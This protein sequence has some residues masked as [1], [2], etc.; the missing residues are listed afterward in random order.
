MARHINHAIQERAN[1][2]QR[3]VEGAEN[4]TSMFTG[5]KARQL[6]EIIRET[7]ER[8]PQDLPRE[9]KEILVTEGISERIAYNKYGSILWNAAEQ[10]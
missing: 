6:C 9:T 7:Y 4:S 10:D 3:G 8:L 1:A 5:S 2:T